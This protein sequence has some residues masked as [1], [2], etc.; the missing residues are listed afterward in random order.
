MD[1]TQLGINPE[2]VYALFG[3]EDEYNNWFKSAVKEELE[4]RQLQAAREAANKVLQETQ[5]T[6]PEGL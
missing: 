6:I 4:R 2:V 5:I 3:G 1:L